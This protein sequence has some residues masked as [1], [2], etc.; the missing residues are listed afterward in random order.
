[1]GMDDVN[2]V[3]VLIGLDGKYEGRKWSLSEPEFVIGRSPECQL[4]VA[5]RQVSRRH[6]RLR[7]GALGHL[8]EDLGSKNGTH[9]NGIRIGKPVSLKDGDEIQVA[10]AVKLAYLGSEATVQLGHPSGEGRLWMDLPGHRV[11]ILNKELDP[12]LSAAQ[13]KLLEVLYRNANR[14][15]AREEVIASVW[16]DT[17]AEGV[18]EQA[19]DALVRRL[20]DRLAQADEEHSYIITV[21]GHGFRI[22]NPP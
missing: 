16:V 19:I 8:L 14:V 21:R 1:M 17:D 18:S 4:V 6:A 7:K 22:D 11:F 12:P 20:R 15:V 13:Y 5:D 2:D 9:V 3:A 10:L